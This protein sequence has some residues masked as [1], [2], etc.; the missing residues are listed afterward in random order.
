MKYSHLQP[1]GCECRMYS[2]NQNKLETNTAWFCL[3]LD[4]KKAHG[5]TQ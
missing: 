2:S 1:H 3:Y 4:S 5:Q